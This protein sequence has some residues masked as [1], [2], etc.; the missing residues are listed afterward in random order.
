MADS[1]GVFDLGVEM[2]D[3]LVL[4]TSAISVMLFED[5]ETH[6]DYTTFLA[7]AVAENTVLVY[8]EL[9]DLEL[10]Q[11]CMKEAR[12]LHSGRRDRFV[13]AGRAL[14]RETF[15]RWRALY[16]ATDSHRIPIGVPAQHDIVGSSVRDAA[17]RLIDL[18]GIDSYDATHAATAVLHAA[19]L[20]CA[21]TGFAHLPQDLLTLITDSGLATKCRA[22]RAGAT[23]P[24]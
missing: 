16:S 7:R 22:I 6:P 18:Y 11:V 21:D 13:P 10:A 4:D 20:L 23:G 1:L 15:A 8:C 14:I 12:R 24:V 2:P 19:P 9:L 5:Q 17:F 3:V